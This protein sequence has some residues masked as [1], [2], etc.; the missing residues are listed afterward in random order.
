MQPLLFLNSGRGSPLFFVTA[1]SFW[2]HFHGYQQH[3][4]V[5][6]SAGGLRGRGRTREHL[7]VRVWWREARRGKEEG[8]DAFPVSVSCFL[9]CVEHLS[10]SPFCPM[11]FKID[12][13][14]I[15]ALSTWVHVCK[16]VAQ[17]GCHI[18]LDL[19]QKSF[20]WED[21]SYSLKKNMQPIH[22]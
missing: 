19:W 18:D 14:F 20:S 1:W 5:L 17:K 11:L 13:S 12:G 8:A 2:I 6:V 16:R 22:A 10:I 9:F 15:I 7:C 3:T 21:S 4:N